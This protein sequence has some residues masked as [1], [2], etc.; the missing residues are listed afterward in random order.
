MNLLPFFTLFRELLEETPIVTCTS[1]WEEYCFK[2]NARWS[3]DHKCEGFGTHEGARLSDD[4][5]AC[6]KCK[7][8]VSIFSSIRD[9]DSALMRRRMNR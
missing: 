9:P 1:C 6:P 2:D 4:L 8:H 5:K 3:E 7:T